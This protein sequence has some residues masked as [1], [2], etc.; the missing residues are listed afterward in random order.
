MSALFLAI[1]A[2]ASAA[3]G[4]AV[5]G[6]RPRPAAP[7]GAVATGFRYCT[8]EFRTRAAIE[9][10][11]GSATCADCGTHIPTATEEDNRA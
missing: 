5:R 4:R 6:P 11:D 2:I 3:V 10:P 7:A 9:H 8:R 1:I